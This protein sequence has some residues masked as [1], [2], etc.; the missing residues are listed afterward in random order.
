MQMAGDN[1]VSFK[2]RT[3]PYYLR[4]CRRVRSTNIESLPDDMVFKILLHLPVEDIYNVAKFVCRKWYHMINSHN[5]I[6]AHVQHSSGLLIQH[7]GAFSSSP[8]FVSM[9]RGQIEISKL[10]YKFRD[11][12]WTSCNGLLLERTLKYGS[13]LYVSNP[14]T[15]QHFALPP[16][17][18]RVFLNTYSGLGYDAASREYKVVHTYVCN[19]Y[20]DGDPNIGCAILTVGV[21]EYWRNVQTEHLCVSARKLFCDTALIT[22]GFMHWVWL[23][24]RRKFLLT[25]NLETE[26]ISEIPIPRGYGG[27]LMYYFP[28]G[29]YL[30]FITVCSEFCWEVWEMKPDTAEWIKL[31]NIDLEARK[32]TLEHLFCKHDCSLKPVG[33]IKY[34]EVLLFRV[35]YPS[36]LCIAYNVCTRE[37][38][39]IEKG[40]TKATNSSMKVTKIH[41][42][43]V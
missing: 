10:S 33:W 19:D 22:E 11:I 31:L 7:L 40:K 21:D 41:D 16:F 36:R 43:P 8:I 35:S 6:Y 15:K 38:E 14:V 29:R 26:T 30:S 42:V 4:R 3:R 9:S 5:F 18:R 28:T 12:V 13:I 27:K 23:G 25:L 24:Y 37:I 20:N 17:N 34:K 1:C 2:C 39:S 32:C